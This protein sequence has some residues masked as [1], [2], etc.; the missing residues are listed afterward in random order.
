MPVSEKEKHGVQHHKQIEE[1]RG[2]G[3]GHTRGE[4]DK[5]R[6]GRFGGSADLFQQ[7][8]LAWH[9]FSQCRKSLHHPVVHVERGSRAKV[10]I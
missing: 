8:L 7:L 4:T 10:L 2:R 1:E 3:C 9:V 6:T 5:K